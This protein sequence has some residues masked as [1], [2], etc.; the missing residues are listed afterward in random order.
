[1]STQRARIIRRLS[2][3][4]YLAI[5]AVHFSSLKTIDVSPKHYA[6][7][8]RFARKDTSA[9]IFGRVLHEMI[10]D[11]SPPAAAIYEGKTRRGKEWDAFAAEHA[12]ETI[13]KRSEIEDAAAMRAALLADPVAGPLLA[14]GHG[15]VTIEWTMLGHPCKGRVDWL[16]PNGAPCELKT[17]KSIVPH[18]FARDCGKYQYHAQQAFYWGGLC[19]ALGRE[20]PELPTL[21]TVEKAPPYDVAVYRVGYDTLEAGQRKIDTWIKRLDEARRTRTWPGVAPAMLDLRLPEWLLTDGL[22]DVDLSGIE[23]EEDDGDE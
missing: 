19:A 21:I 5:D 23:G 22:A 9:L 3:A 1:M 13:L 20:P 14:E 4:D 16:R 6:H 18:A 7:A 2:F 17:T 15:E 8:Q 11:P 10:L 12:G